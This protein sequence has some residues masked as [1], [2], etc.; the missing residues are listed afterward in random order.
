MQGWTDKN[1]HFLYEK[2]SK[3]GL[4][5]ETNH[6][7]TTWLDPI[8]LPAPPATHVGELGKSFCEREQQ[9]STSFFFLCSLI[10]SPSLTAVSVRSVHLSLWV[11]VELYNS[12]DFSTL[13]K[14]WVRWLDNMTSPA[15]ARRTSCSGWRWGSLFTPTY[16]NPLRRSSV[17]FGLNVYASMVWQVLFHIHVRFVV[18]ANETEYRKP[19]HALAVYTLIWW[20]WW[21]FASHSLTLV[22]WWQRTSPTRS[23]ACCTKFALKRDAI[24]WLWLILRGNDQK[25]RKRSCKVVLHC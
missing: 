19:L 20:S 8:L 1:F 25:S 12:K 2:S 6:K 24:K 14:M 23:K 13:R 7:W 9:T 4:R 18:R 5:L 11:V 10:V 22:S 21:L 16:S 3:S 17:S 15:L